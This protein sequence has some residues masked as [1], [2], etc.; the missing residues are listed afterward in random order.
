MKTQVLSMLGLMAA[1]VVGM[2]SDY[3]V[4]LPQ[5][6]HCPPKAS[7]YR[8]LGGY[9][10]YKKC[11][12]DDRY[13]EKYDYG[14][15]DSYSRFNLSYNQAFTC[16]DNFRY[17]LKVKFEAC[18]SENGYKECLKVYYE[19]GYNSQKR[20]DGYESIDKSNLGIY[21]DEEDLYRPESL[22]Y[23]N[24]CHGNQCS[25]PTDYLPGYPDLCGKNIYLAVGNDLCYNNYEYEDDE[26]YRQSTKHISVNVSCNNEEHYDYNKG[27]KDY[28]CC[29]DYGY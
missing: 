15:Y 27:C 24:Y 18:S 19:N 11:Y 5:C 12:K 1:S 25:V 2:P 20:G 8:S 10:E 9:D 22:N 7:P 29:Y 21:L 16:P 23:N 17:D 14:Y 28:C 13:C 6:S 26:M 3:D 4:G